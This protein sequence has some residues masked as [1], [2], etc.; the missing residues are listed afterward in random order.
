MDTT[1]IP[2]QKKR[3]KALSEV[4]WKRYIP[5]L[6]DSLFVREEDPPH[7]RCSLNNLGYN[8]KISIH[9]LFFFDSIGI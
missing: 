7:K 8:I 5:Y 1:K 3:D 9:F 6:Y 2:P 4:G